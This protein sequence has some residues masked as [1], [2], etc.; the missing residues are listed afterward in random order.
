M[1]GI[2]GY[3]NIDIN[4]YTDKNIVQK[5]TNSLI[6]RGPDQSGIYFH[7]NVALGHR[8]LSIIDCKSGKQPLS[9]EDNTIWIVFNGEIYNY[10][11][12]KRDLLSKGHKFK[13]NTDTEVII[14]SYEQW[15]IECFNMLE[16]MMAC[17]IFDQKKQ[18]L[19]L[20]RDRFGQKPLYYTLQNNVF[21]FASEIKA[22]RYHP[23][24]ELIHS[25]ESINRYLSYEYVPAPKTIF[26]NIFQLLPGNFIEISTSNSF[27]V[28]NKQLIPKQYWKLQF[29]PKWEGSFDDAKIKYQNLFIESVEKRL[30][31]DVPLGVFL[32]GGIDSSSIV[33][34]LTQIK[35]SSEINTFS[36]G[37]NEKSFDESYYAKLVSNHFSTNHH[38]KIF[39]EKELLE[40]IPQVFDQMDEPFADP[41]ILPVYLLSKFTRE[42]VTVVLGGDGSDEFLAGYD[43]FIAL[44]LIN[45]FRFLP[46]S[47]ISLFSKIIKIIPVNN[48]N[49]STWFKL[50][51]FF[52]GFT[53]ETKNCPELLNQLW[54]SAFTHTNLPFNNKNLMTFQEL[55]KPT[56]N[57]IES[58]Y[59]DI[60][61][62]SN[63]FIQTY[64]HN[65]ILRKIDRASMMN[66]LEVRNPFLDTKLAEF[67]AQLPIEYKMKG[68]TSKYI[69][70]EIMKN[71][72]PDNIV[73]RK[74]KGFGIPLAKWIKNEL[75]ID[76]TN[77]IHSLSSSIHSFDKDYCLNILNQHIKGKANYQKK[78]WAIY[79]LNKILNY[80]KFV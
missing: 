77:S 38:T 34:A 18:K 40:T 66:S 6:H 30:M 47:I 19:L 80:K 44:K 63:S 42:Y 4:H 5:M 8:R 22:F 27:Q 10:P 61:R 78:L 74:K 52:K 79:V 31:S 73:Y 13:T 68:F 70:K 28:E 25:T 46:T 9:N 41:S 54:L 20:A 1:C 36:I 65:D 14:H 29:T 16:G 21:L 76:I 33:W 11:N 15:G 32:S 69:L 60:D 55:Y 56:Y 43:P 24:I 67:S 58:E 57:I 45:Y 3:F 64:L 53:K 48:N 72:L 71:N 62:F 50:Y 51:H 7:K 35:K 75:K 26:N 23:Q 2:T 12:L 59:H 37:F 39:N 49:M 17:A